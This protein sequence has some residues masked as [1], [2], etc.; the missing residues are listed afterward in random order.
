MGEEM[1]RLVLLR[2]G[3]S[4]A[5]ANGLFTGALDVP[6]TP[7]GIRESLGGAELVA[8]A[9]VAIAAIFSSP[10][11]RARTSA[12]I[13]AA[14]LD[15]DLEGV[16]FDWR[17]IERSY[18][19][20]TGQSK[21]DVLHR[22]GSQQFRHWRRSVTG[23]PPRM[24]EALHRRLAAQASFHGLPSEALPYT[25]S[26]R[27]VITRLGPF[28]SERV[29]PRLRTGESIL[30]VAHGNSLRAVCAILDKLDDD[31]IADLNIPTGHPLVYDFTP[32]LT[33][34]ARG[35]RYLDEESALAAAAEVAA[36]G[37]T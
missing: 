4:V 17:L 10:L 23:M 28:V 22:Y 29:F 30:L 36:Q 34:V 25:E 9:G 26:L 2:H 11:R 5:N 35:G 33:P 7:A 18:G 16:E 14:S 8:T 20:L 6:L 37:G 21:A 13:A 32:E 31:E 15:F 24:S 12:T 3:E 19:A 27:D 1:G